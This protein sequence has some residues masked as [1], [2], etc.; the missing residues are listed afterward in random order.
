MRAMIF[1]SPTVVT[2][3]GGVGSQIRPHRMLR[4]F[5]EEGWEVIEVTG[6]HRERRRA[7]EEAMDRVDAGGA[8]F[9]YSELSSAPIALSEPWRE[10]VDP[11]MDFSLFAR[12]RDKGVPVGAFYRDIYW[13]F[14]GYLRAAGL[15]YGLLARHHYRADLRRLNATVD[16][17]FLP[18]LQMGRYVPVVDPGKFTELPP[19]APV[20][21]SPGAPGVHLFYVGGLGDYY[22]LRE[23]V[24]AVAQVSEV[25]LTMCVPEAQWLAHRHVYEPLLTDRIRVVHG[26]GSDLDAFYEQA[27][28]GVL[29][30]KPIEYRTFAAPIKLFEYIGRALPVLAS[31]GTYAGDWVS[32]NGVGWAAPYDREELARAL[33]ALV[34]RPDLVEQAREAALSAREENTWGARARQVARDL[35]AVRT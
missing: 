29:A 32:S 17:L 5:A 12:C 34:A 25:H 28:I 20:V 19:G 4:A 21:D 8:D 6:R 2:E 14:P 11:E 13:R 7:I 10:R 23:C 1:H 24:A 16:I 18:T 26:R 9:L 30:M 15:A 27:S 3:G 31:Q 22:D 33:S 35:G